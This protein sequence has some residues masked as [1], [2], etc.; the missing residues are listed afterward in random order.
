M[1]SS[2]KF[3]RKEEELKKLLESL[4]IPQV[5]SEQFIE[6]QKTDPSLITNY[7][8]LN[9]IINIQICCPNQIHS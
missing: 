3:H 9:F 1:S 7:I 4:D 5:G 2:G 8:N 6:Q